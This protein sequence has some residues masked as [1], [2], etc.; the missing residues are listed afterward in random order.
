MRCWH[1]KVGIKDEVRPLVSVSAFTLTNWWQEGH[2]TI[3]KT[4]LLISRGSLPEQMEEKDPVRNQLTQVH[5]EKWPSIGSNS[6]SKDI[7]VIVVFL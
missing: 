3:K 5:L 2:P 6:S 7:L 1:W 4:I